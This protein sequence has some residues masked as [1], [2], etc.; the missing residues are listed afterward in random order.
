MIGQTISHYRIVEKLGAGGMGVVYEAKDTRLE[1]SVALKFLPEEFFDNP[2]AL[3]RFRREAK[4][5]S[6]MDHP[7]I[8]TVHDI[9]E[10]AGQP[11]ISMQLLRGQTLKHRIA[12]GPL[13]TEELLELG[14]QLADALDAAHSKGIVHRDI[15]PANIFVTERGQAKVLDFGLAKVGPKGGTGAKD[16]AG[17]EVST[18]LKEED[19]TSP[20]SALGTVAYMSPEQARGEDLDARTDLFS[21]GV[22]LYE[23]ATGQHAF[24]G[25]SSVVIFDAIL[26]KTPTAPVRLNPEVSPKLEEI[27]G[28]ALDKDRELRYQSAADLRTDLKRLK[29]DS[30]SGKSA[31]HEADGGA[32]RVAAALPLGAAPLTPVGA[33][34]GRGGPA[35]GRRR[36]GMVV[37]V[38]SRCGGSGRAGQDHPLHDRRG[39]QR[40][41]PAFPGRREG[42]L[43]LDGSQRRRI[44]DL[45]QGGGFRHP[46]SSRDRTHGPRHGR[47]LVPG[48]PATCL[49]ACGR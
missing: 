22:V 4:A 30:D 29:R 11:F 15:K 24:T 20:G 45:R 12:A 41:P 48:C 35:G 13:K 42:G 36:A 33:A 8:C 47:R 26:H 6:A 46:T 16:A 3:E 32:G 10:H 43:P 37:P 40:L 2:I 31:A 39:F 18:Q 34:S 17:S 38:E 25:S 27:I 7:N 19:L 49:R 28:K 1:R 9:D 44:E 5:A 23:M 21:F 14:I